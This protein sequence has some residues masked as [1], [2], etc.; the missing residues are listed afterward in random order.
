MT[1]LYKVA[2]LILL[3]SGVQLSAQT[4]SQPA[5][6]SPEQAPATPTAPAPAQAETAAPSDAPASASTPLPDAPAARTETAHSGR[7]V[8]DWSYWTV[9]GAL[10]G[11]TVADAQALTD[12]TNCTYVPSTFHRPGLLYGAGLPADVIVMYIGYDLKKH[13][14]RWWPAPAVAL[15]VLNAYLAYHSYSKAN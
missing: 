4:T 14:H 3:A 1:S 2:L 5:A 9:N 15:T 13:G 8:L 11:A 10:I 7:K 6:S 12:C